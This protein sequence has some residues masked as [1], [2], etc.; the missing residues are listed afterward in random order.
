ML[1]LG[2]H[3][4]D[5]EIGAGATI[6]KIV[7]ENPDIHVT[8]VVL[9]APAP[10]DKEAALAAELFLAA[11]KSRDVALHQ[12]RDSFFPA[13]WTELKQQFETIRRTV[14]PDVVLTHSTADKHQD[15]RLVGELT[16]NAFRDHLILEYEIPKFDGDLGQ[17]NFYVPTSAEDSKRKL[18]ILQTAFATQARKDW[19]D[20]A[21]FHGLMRLRGMECRSKSR[22]A[23]GFYAKKLSIE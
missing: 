4:D 8:W 15:H 19:F 17:P 9:S 3:S 13:Q 23:E 16:W 11:A 14:E 1:C 21:V 18:E 10:R 7:R 12:F 5:L 22:L 2:A 6:L 20:E